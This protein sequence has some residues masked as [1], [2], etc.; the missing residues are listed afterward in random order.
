MESIFVEISKDVLGTRK[1]VVIGVIY[2][3]PNNNLSY[4]NEKI[5]HFLDQMQRENNIVYLLGDYNV[6]LINSDTHD[7]TAEFTDI[8]YSNE[9][10]PLISRPT[11]ITPDSTTL[12]DNIFTNN[13]DDVNNSLN[14]L[15]VTDISDHFPIFHVNRSLSVEEIDSSFVTRVFNERNKQ[16]YLEAISETDWSE[17]CNVHDTQKSFDLFHTKL[18]TFYNK[19]FPKIRI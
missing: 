19:Y 5:S 13:H 4:F 2:R 10:L 16:A 8:M 15:L 18:I 9:F 1:N 14:G 3:I 17:I 6:N 12:I 11:R 7:L